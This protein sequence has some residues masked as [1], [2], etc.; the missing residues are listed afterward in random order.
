MSQRD[1]RSFGRRRGRKLR[2]YQAEI[3]TQWLPRLAILPEQLLACD[4]KPAFVDV[5]NL[6]ASHSAP[7]HLEIGFGNGEYLLHR[8]QCHPEINYIGA[9]PFENGV[10]KLVGHIV[11]SYNQKGVENPQKISN[12][13]IFMDDVRLL[14]DCL[15]DACLQ[16]VDILFPDPWP[17]AR[18]YRRRLLQPSLIKRLRRVMQPQASLCVATDHTDYLLNILILMQKNNDFKW[19]STMAEHWRRPWFNFYTRYAR[20]ANAAGCQG[21]YLHY[22]LE[23]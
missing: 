22:T 7:L 9:E 5:H 6:F 4:R 20:R 23:K 21:Y 11:D 10:A 3:F 12:I 14:L 15:P 1:F 19:N 16:R 18:H 17:K 2:P 8:A 13:R